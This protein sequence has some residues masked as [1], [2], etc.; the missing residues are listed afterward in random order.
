VATAVVVG[1]LLPIPIG[2]GRILW[3]LAL[4]ATSSIAALLVDRVAR[5]LLPLAVLLRLSL[6][7]PDAAP[8]RFA[9]A[10]NA[11]NQRVLE[12][13]IRF[14][15]QH[16]LDDDPARAAEEILRLVAALSLHDKKTR[17]HAERV[18]VLTD[19]VSEE[20]GL[21]R[22]ARDR[23]RWAA[24]LHDIGKLRVPAQVL[25]KDGKPN[26]SEWDLLKRHPEEGAR[27]TAPL[28]PWLGEWG[29]AIVQH[30]ERFD[31][32]GYPNGLAGHEISLGAR[33]VAVVDSFEVMTAARSYKKPISVVDARKELV[34][35]AGG[36]FDPTIVRAFLNLSVGKL[37]IAV[38]AYPW[39]AQLPFIERLLSSGAAP[40]AAPVMSKSVAGIVA[41]SV[42]GGTGTAFADAPDRPIHVVAATT[43]AP[44]AD[45]SDR[46]TPAPTTDT[47]TPAQEPVPGGRPDPAPPPEPG[48]DQGNGTPSDPGSQGQDGGN[49][50]GNG[51]GQPTD[52][53][54]GNGGGNDGGQPTDPGGGNGGGQPTDPG[55]GNGG[56]QPTDP[57]GGNGGGNGGGQPTDPGG[58]NGGGNGGGQPTD[59]GS[60]GQGGGNGGGQPTDPGQPPVIGRR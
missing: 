42:A 19:M 18:R 15:R 22:D 13:R 50:G 4:F 39:V 43:A 52:P 10:R 34:T 17:G 27:L 60:Q 6:I 58:G 41:L 29:L 48:D 53:G 1:H 14:A 56:G 9:V 59:P 7:F 46:V 35:C 32:D 57:G 12:E 55:G 2:A 28:L 20:I 31:G 40:V 21:P 5:R 47:D 11:G 51:G 45:G 30:H 33:V 24:L 44:E 54:G 3:L 8:S 16:G 49:G 36:Q 23:L 25:N 37:R 38:G 26:A